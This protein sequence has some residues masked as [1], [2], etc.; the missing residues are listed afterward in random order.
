MTDRQATQMWDL[1]DALMEV[2]C[3]LLL[4]LII[5]SYNTVDFYSVGLLD[6]ESSK[7]HAYMM[8]ENC[9]NQHPY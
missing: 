1:H 5:I 7:L 6:L 4:R 2:F 9:D 8:C 3:A